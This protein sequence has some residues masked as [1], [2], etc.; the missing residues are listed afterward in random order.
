[1]VSPDKGPELFVEA[2]A[3]VKSPFEAVM[4]GAG[5]A[6]D[7]ARRKA[8]ELRLS[9]KVRFV[10]FLNREQME[11]QYEWC[12]AV[13]FTSVWAEPFGYVGVEAA[14]HAR[15]VVA[16]NVGAVTEWLSDGEGGYIVPRFQCNSMAVRINRLA[17]DPKLRRAMGL[18]HRRFAEPRYNKS[19][20][21][22][23]LLQ[24]YSE[25]IGN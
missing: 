10:G 18:G 15:P 14:A 19:R 6:K 21:I 2:L 5:P 20:H 17:R 25:V 1:M 13:V 23:R 24:I 8:E 7:F 22:E 11:R 4:A 3:H 9:S 12:H 16:F